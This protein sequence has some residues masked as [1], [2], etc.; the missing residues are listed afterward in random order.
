MEALA[1]ARHSPKAI[2]ALA[3][4]WLAEQYA[5]E[6]VKDITLE[7]VRF[8]R[9]IWHIT[10]GFKRKRVVTRVTVLELA[11]SAEPPNYE[12]ALKVVSISDNTGEVISMRDRITD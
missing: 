11:I 2:I 1:K 5:D 9:G 6:D 4:Q 12:K 7:E 10:I 3:K 8:G